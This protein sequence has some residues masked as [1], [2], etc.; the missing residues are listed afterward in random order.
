MTLNC[1]NPQGEEERANTRLFVG[2]QLE[3]I[4]KTVAY[5]TEKAVRDYYLAINCPSTI[6]L[7]ASIEVDQQLCEK[8]RKVLINSLNSVLS[9]F[10]TI[11]CCVY[12][13][14]IVV[15]VGKI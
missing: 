2:G 10:T 11:K 15:L 5:Q 13:L 7:M 3:S 12:E 1:D 14:D 4:K 9:K 8:D 6:A